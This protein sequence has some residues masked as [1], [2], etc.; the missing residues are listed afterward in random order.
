MTI[1]NDPNNQVSVDDPIKSYHD[2]KTTRQSIK[3][4]LSGGTPNWVRFPNDYRAFVK[5]S[6]QAE[7]EQS[8]RQVAQYRM[9]DQDLLVD[10]KP[11]MVN[12][13]TTRDFLKKLKRH[14]LK[15]FTFNNPLMP[16]TVGLWVKP[17]FTNEMKYIAYM[18]VPCMYEWSVL[19]LDR[20]GLPNGEDFRGWRTIL[21]QLVEKQILTEKE[22]HKIFGR[23]TDSIVSRR[24]RK[25]LYWFRNRSFQAAHDSDG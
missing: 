4:L 20:H 11:R 24:Y 14:G 15:C 1:Y 25:S 21:Y 9:D 16:Q 17:K 7:K 12:I 18:Q 22:V 6:F 8:D 5:E 3:Q 23:P 13:L 19:R 10:S 2:L